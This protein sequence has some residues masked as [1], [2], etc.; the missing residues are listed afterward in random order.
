MLK[1]QTAVI[2]F[3]SK[4]IKIV[5]AGVESGDEFHVGS[6]VNLTDEICTLTE[7]RVDRLCKIGHQ[8]LIY[9]K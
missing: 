6:I 7:S 9:L 4:E 8:V 2:G 5:S 3:M 1:A